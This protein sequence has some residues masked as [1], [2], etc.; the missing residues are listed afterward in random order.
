MTFEQAIRIV[1]SANSSLIIGC[2]A[3]SALFFSL[4]NQQRL[5]RKVAHTIGFVGF[6]LVLEFGRYQLLSAIKEPYTQL[7]VV[8]TLSF[9]L[10]FS[11]GDWLSYLIHLVHVKIAGGKGWIEAARFLFAQAKRFE[12]FGIQYMPDV[13]RK[14]YLALRTQA[15]VDQAKTILST[16]GHLNAAPK[17]TIKP[18]EKTLQDEESTQAKDGVVF[19]YTEPTPNR[20]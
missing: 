3:I 19:V 5:T 9:L 14:A 7:P 2:I 8:Y 15:H 4:A 12:R 1:W 10:S 18:G 16:N 17:P 20:V 13:D 6:G 11:I